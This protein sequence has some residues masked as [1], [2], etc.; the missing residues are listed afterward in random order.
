MKNARQLSVR[1]LARHETC[2]MLRETCYARRVSRSARFTE[3]YI[4][5]LLACVPRGPRRTKNPGP[6][7]RRGK[8]GSCPGPPQ[9]GGRHK[10]SKKLLPTETQKMLFESVN[11]E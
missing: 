2:Y 8:L 5:G 11:L 3:Q 4:A 7:L 10:N 6:G 1:R 9:L